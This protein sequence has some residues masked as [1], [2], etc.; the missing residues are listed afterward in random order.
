MKH[1][2]IVG[3][4][5]IT[6]TVLTGAVLAVGLLLADNIAPWLMQQLDRKNQAKRFSHP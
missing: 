2:S 6:D 3:I 4:G 5:L 1:H